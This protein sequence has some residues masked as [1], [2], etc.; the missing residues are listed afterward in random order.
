MSN[1]SAAHKDRHIPLARC[2][3]AFGIE[4]RADSGWLGSAAAT[5]TECAL[6]GRPDGTHPG[7]WRGFEPLC[8]P[9]QA[10]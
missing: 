8:L 6:W 5:E 7:N 3:T 4:L 2:S 10:E 1:E 9:L